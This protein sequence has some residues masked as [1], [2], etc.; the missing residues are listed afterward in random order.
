MPGTRSALLEHL[1]SQVQRLTTGALDLLFPPRC[2]GC[3]RPGGDLCPSC[4]ASLLR[5]DGPLCAVCAQPVPSQGLCPRCA[6]RRPAFERVSSAFVYTG[7]T[8]QAILALKFR[9]RRGLAEVLARAA[10]DSLAPPHAG[11]A[12]CPVPMHPSRLA[13]RGYNH[14]GLLADA[15]AVIWGLPCLPDE[16]LQRVAHTPQQARLDYEARLANVSAA[17]VA[18]RR[19][20]AGR[21]VLLVDDVCTTGAT[22]SACAAALRASGAA[23]VLGVTVAR[24][25]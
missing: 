12:L 18:D 16:A 25:P 13:Q 11:A 14:A 6:A 20:V 5:L 7:T 2:V 21:D 3:R 1:T 10:A 17:F 9:G 19:H 22:L 8:R 15:L 24:T 4:A 23:R